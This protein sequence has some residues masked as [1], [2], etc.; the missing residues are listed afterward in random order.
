MK[1]FFEK[2]KPKYI[3]I[4][5]LFFTAS[6][7]WFAVYGAG[8]G[9]LQVVF[10]DVGQGDAIF[11]E[12]PEGVQVLIDGGPNKSVLGELS[13]VMPF[14]DRSIDAV[15]LTHPH[16][17]HVGGLVEVLKRYEV[18]Y[19]VESGA[20]H[21]IAEFAEWHNLLEK[22]GV[23][24][25]QARRGLRLELGGGI[26]LDFLL[27]EKME[28]SDD[29]H[30]NMAV[31]RLS[32]GRTCFLF[33]GDMERE[34]EWRILEDNIGCQVLKVGH[35]GSKTSTSDA[36]LEAVKPDFAVISAGRANRYGHPNEAILEKLGASGA[37]GFR[38][39][40]AASIFMESDGKEISASRNS[41]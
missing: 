18:G 7:A 31:S 4:L 34:L 26:L 14:Y 16:L 30:K 25:V 6:L 13:E 19:A 32:Y 39:G 27:P 10:L 29:P 15:V 35:H 11:V 3:F 36:F 37:K 22:M 12:T 38:T 21:S 1:K 9:T 5:G 40:L 33:T 20:G 41:L 24:K 28:E 17:D 8:R 23:A 2:Y